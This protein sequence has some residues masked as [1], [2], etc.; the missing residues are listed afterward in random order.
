MTA[1]DLLLA[2]CEEIRE[3]AERYPAWEVALMRDCMAAS[4]WMGVGELPTR[5]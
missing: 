2:C 5:N 3:E 4:I 1:P